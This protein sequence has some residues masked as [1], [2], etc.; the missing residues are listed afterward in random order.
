MST[1]R[2]ARARAARQSPIVRLYYDRDGDLRAGRAMITVGGLAF[3][4]VLG[5]L[6]ASFVGAATNPGTLALGAMIVFL[7]IKIPLLAVVF[8]ILMRQGGGPGE[9]EW[10][11][12]ERTE[13]LDYLIRQATEAR[14]TPNQAEHI[15][16]LAREAWHVADTAPDDERAAAVAVAVEIGAMR[17]P[18]EGRTTV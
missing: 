16:W 14:G 11:P 12:R 17:R 15:T 2:T 4:V 10:S 18:A 3:L 13:I 7:A 9:A 6:V 1:Q 5:T 8:W